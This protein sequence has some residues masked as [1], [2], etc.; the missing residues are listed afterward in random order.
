MVTNAERIV[1]KAEL[2]LPR[3]DVVAYTTEVS[4]TEVFVRTDAGLEI[5]DAIEVR[6]SFPRLLA[7][8]QFHGHVL[9]KEPGAGHGYSPGVVVGFAADTSEQRQWL[10]SLLAT[11]RLV[12]EQI[13]E[14][15]CRILV[16]EDSPLVRDFVHVGAERFAGHIRVIVDT[17]ETP[18][19]ARDLLAQHAYDLALVD[20]YLPG[21]RTGADLVRE[22]R[23]DKSDL[24]VIGFSVGG[25]AARDALFEA[26]ADIFIEKPVT[27]K[28]VFP[29]LER[30]LLMRGAR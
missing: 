8:L 9:T 10:A 26:G 14:P 7:P 13:T 24:P 12:A 18:E 5:G 11:P 17:A 19:V 30:L 28:D 22:L 4:P 2:L 21:V 6:L 23:K 25:A 1:L 3:G 27:M 16:V 15:S 20:F 29:T